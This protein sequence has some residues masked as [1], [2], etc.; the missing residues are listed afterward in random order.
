[1]AP[2]HA[3]GTTHK[4]ISVLLRFGEFASSAIVL[5]LLSRISYLISDAHAHVDGRIIYAM[6]VAG[7]S[8]VYSVFFCPPFKSLFLSFPVDFILFVMWLIAYCLLQTRTAGRGCSA[9]WYI[10]YWGWYW[11]RYDN[12]GCGSWRTVLAFSFIAWV[13]HLA[14]GILGAYVFH[15]YIRLEETKR[16]FKH[17]AEKLTR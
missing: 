9:R 7:M 11:D 15:T 5:G 8:I 3:T 17:H 1:M 6:V 16:D 2:E 13:L 10:T 14:S 12:G 4:V